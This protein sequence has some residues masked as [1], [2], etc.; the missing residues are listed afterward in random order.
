MVAVPG[1]EPGRSNDQQILMVVGI[2]AAPIIA[3]GHP[4]SAAPAKLRHTAINLLLLP[5]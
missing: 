1:F 5:S 3:T 4:P 2:G